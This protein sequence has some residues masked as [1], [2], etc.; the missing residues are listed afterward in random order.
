MSNR[1]RHSNRVNGVGFDRGRGK[2]R[3]ALRKDGREISLG[4]FDEKKD[5]VAAVEAAR[6]RIEH[7]DRQPWKPTIPFDVP[8]PE[9]RKISAARVPVTNPVKLKEQHA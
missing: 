3:A 7:I 8:P 4:S 1:V 6:N 9:P 2:W 5:A